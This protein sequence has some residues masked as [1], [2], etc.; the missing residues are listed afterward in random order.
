[1]LISILAGELLVPFIMYRC[2]GAAAAPYGT[3][4]IVVRFFVYALHSA[5]HSISHVHIT[6]AMPPFSIITLT[7]MLLV[8]C[9]DLL[10]Y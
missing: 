5:I 1:M 10:T 9:T 3:Y 4:C 2:S 6:C 8:Q 7:L